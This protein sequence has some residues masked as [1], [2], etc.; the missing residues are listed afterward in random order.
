VRRQASTISGI[1]VMTL[2]NRHVGFSPVDQR[3]PALDHAV[4]LQPLDPPPAWRGAEADLFG[5][6]GHRHGAIDLKNIEN[7]PV[8]GVQQAGLSRVM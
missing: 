4:I 3:H 6:C 2:R 1:V 7:F 8:Y 5:N